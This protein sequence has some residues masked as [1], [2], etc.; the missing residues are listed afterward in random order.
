MNASLPRSRN[1]TTV[2]RHPRR[3]FA[4]IVVRRLLAAPLL[5]FFLVALAVTGYQL[6]APQREPAAISP[7]IELPPS[8]AAT[9]CRDELGRSGA[10]A[11]GRELAALL[12]RG[13]DDEILLRVAL[14]RNLHRS[15][16][17]ASARLASNIAFIGGRAADPATLVE[18]AIAM[19]MAETDLV[20][21]RRLIGRMK[22]EIEGA[23]R[24]RPVRDERLARYLS[25]H[26]RR[27]RT[28]PSYRFTQ[29]FL[30]AARHGPSD[31]EREAE[32]I[33]RLLGSTGAA[34]G[35]VAIGDPVLAG[36]SSTTWSK[37]DVLK[38]F[39]PAIEHALDEAPVGR[40]TGP[41]R[42]AL[43]LH[44][45]R[46]EER[47]PARVPALDEIRERVRYDFLARRG[48]AALARAIESMR[49]KT[50]VMLGGVPID[51]VIDRLEHAP[52]SLRR[53]RPLS[54][55]EVEDC[56]DVLKLERMA[57][58]SPAQPGGKRS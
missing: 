8:W 16:P 21:R 43:G 51:R 54:I 46:L 17:V 15:D 55:F 53:S 4:R 50:Q 56:A 36:A 2:Q 32:R 14:A 38:V 48:Q 6:S 11:R 25:H 1:E 37:A 44:W 24:A 42:T 5:H 47:I 40:W 58:G 31:L 26:Q 28:Q 45:L 39:G 23:A 20:V 13:A 52:G 35:D 22:L 49:T 33:D 34:P 29:V 3:R 30:S 10:L 9:L 41:V 7:K 18:R 19:G 12:R 27:Y 57:T